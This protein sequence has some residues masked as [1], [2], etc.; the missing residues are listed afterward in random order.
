MNGYDTEKK[1]AKF[2]HVKLKSYVKSRI[3]MRL[4]VLDNRLRRWEK[5]CLLTVKL[6]VKVQRA[7]FDW[8]YDR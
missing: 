2:K 8:K 5:S 1:V 3:G 6:E 4:W 7:I